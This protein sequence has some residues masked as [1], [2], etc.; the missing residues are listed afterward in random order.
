MAN[1]LGGNVTTSTMTIESIVEKYWGSEYRAP[2]RGTYVFAGGS[3]RFDSTDKFRSGI[4]GVE[5][6]EA[7][8]VQNDF[9]RR[10]P[11]MAPPVL[12]DNDGEVLTQ[13]N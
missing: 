11:D 9:T 5:V 4:Y 8:E 7:I 13:E 3:R 12:L 1:N 10:Y 2:D 6:P